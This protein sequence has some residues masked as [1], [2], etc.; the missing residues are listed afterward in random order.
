[1]TNKELI[2][3]INELEIIHIEDCTSQRDLEICLKAIRENN[4]K[5]PEEYLLKQIQMFKQHRDNS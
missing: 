5:Y 3:E 2:E 1:M 4:E